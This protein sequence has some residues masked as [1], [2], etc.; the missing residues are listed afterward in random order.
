MHA[1]Q[2]AAPQPVLDRADRALVL[3]VEVCL[4]LRLEA[5]NEHV[6]GDEVGEGEGGDGGGEDGEEGVEEGNYER[7]IESVPGWG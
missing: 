4:P 7:C 3:A 5:A 1:P 2:P 6:P